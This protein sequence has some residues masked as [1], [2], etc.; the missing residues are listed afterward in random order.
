MRIA[1]QQ[2]VKRTLE[3][4][5]FAQFAQQVKTVQDAYRAAQATGSEP[6][7]VSVLELL[8]ETQVREGWRCAAHSL[9]LASS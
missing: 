4:M 3:E 6:L 7:V 5:N 2:A 9:A 8:N 1:P